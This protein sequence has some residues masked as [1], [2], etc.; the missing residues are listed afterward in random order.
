MNGK[1]LFI[2]RFLQAADDAVTLP[3]SLETQPKSIRI[4]YLINLINIRAGNAVT[5]KVS[6]ISFSFLWISA[7]NS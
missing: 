6:L 7:A 1:W 5:S 2:V 4:A 3:V